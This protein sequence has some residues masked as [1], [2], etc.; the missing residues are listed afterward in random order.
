MSEAREQVGLNALRPVVQREWLS[1][2]Q[3]L[4]VHLKKASQITNRHITHH[5]KKAEGQSKAHAVKAAAVK[6]ADSRTSSG[7]GFGPPHSAQAD[8]LISQ[9]QARARGL[10]P[11]PAARQ[12]GRVAVWPR[13]PSQVSTHTPHMPTTAREAGARL[14]LPPRP[15]QVNDFLRPYLEVELSDTYPGR[16]GKWPC[17]IQR[18]RT[19]KWAGELGNATYIRP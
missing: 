18:M 3:V 17:T 8:S 16:N 12:P 2:S 11:G 1:A 19:T 7:I 14:Q 15:P 13:W 6:A 9:R 4:C 5:K 10:G